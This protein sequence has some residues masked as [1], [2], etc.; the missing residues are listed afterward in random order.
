MPSG[1]GS[2]RM[3]SAVDRRLRE[4]EDVLGFNNTPG[5]SSQV[6]GHFQEY[7]HSNLVCVASNC[8]LLEND[9]CLVFLGTDRHQYF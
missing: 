7:I 6:G 1:V 2:R 9:R 5:S 4:W 8:P 3:P